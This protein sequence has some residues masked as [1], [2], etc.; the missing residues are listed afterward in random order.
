MLLRH[1]PLSRLFVLHQAGHYTFR[2]CH[3]AL[4]G[5]GGLTMGTYFD[6]LLSGAAPH[7]LCGSQ[8]L[9]VPNYRVEGPEMPRGTRSDVGPSVLPTPWYEDSL[10]DVETRDLGEFAFA[11]PF[12]RPALEDAVLLTAVP[13]ERE[14]GFEAE[15]GEPRFWR[16]MRLGQ[17][18]AIVADWT[19]DFSSRRR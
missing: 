15:R 19:N 14:G 10:V 6:A 16:K 3:I 12:L 4:P 9:F 1:R 7:E 13:T 5:D 8:W 2:G 18:P 17:A 11:K